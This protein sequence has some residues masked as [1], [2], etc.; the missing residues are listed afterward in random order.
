MTA[1]APQSKDKI[2]DKSPFDC[3]IQLADGF[4]QGGNYFYNN[5]SSFP[6]SSKCLRKRWTNSWRV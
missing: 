1:E 2:T 5:P 4:A 3:A 6:A